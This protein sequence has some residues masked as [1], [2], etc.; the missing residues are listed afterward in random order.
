M[1]NSDS[2]L[3]QKGQKATNVLILL[4]LPGRKA[5]DVEGEERRQAGRNLREEQERKEK[6]EKEEDTGTRKERKI[7]GGGANKMAWVSLERF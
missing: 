4:C 1:S 5:A 3:Q 6:E 2:I 7:G